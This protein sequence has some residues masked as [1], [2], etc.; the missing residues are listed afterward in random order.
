MLSWYL[1]KRE[2]G[3]NVIFHKQKK[4]QLTGFREHV[5]QLLRFQMPA[6]LILKISSKLQLQNLLQLEINYSQIQSQLRTNHSPITCGRGDAASCDYIRR[7][8][9]YKIAAR[10]LNRTTMCSPSCMSV[11]MHVHVTMCWQAAA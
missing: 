3:T 4:N 11:W 7:A 1:S 2:Y 6:S 10:H 5:C 9:H 8:Q